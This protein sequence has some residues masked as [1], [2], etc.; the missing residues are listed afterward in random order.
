MMDLVLLGKKQKEIAEELG[1]T[2]QAVCSIVNSTVFREHL[3]IRLIEI[4]QNP[5]GEKFSAL[6]IIHKFSEEAAQKLVDMLDSEDP[7]IRMSAAT[8]ILDRAG[9]GRYQRQSRNE[10]AVV[11]VANL[12]D[13]NRIESIFSETEEIKEN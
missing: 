8:D 6:G 12:D 10:K 3:P 4:K 9:Y 13:L 7:R 2:P 5:E 11:V 1:L